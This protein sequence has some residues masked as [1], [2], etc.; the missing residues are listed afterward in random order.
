MTNL[1]PPSKSPSSHAVAVHENSRHGQAMGH[2]RGG[3]CH[4]AG[5]RE[6][7]RCRSDP[8]R[9]ATAWSYDAL[10]CS[11]S[12]MKERERAHTVMVRRSKL[13]RAMLRQGAARARQSWDLGRASTARHDLSSSHAFQV[14]EAC[15]AALNNTVNIFFG[16]STAHAT[17]VCL[18]V[19]LAQAELSK[20]LSQFY[21]STRDINYVYYVY[22]FNKNFNDF[23]NLLKNQMR[24]NIVNARKLYYIIVEMSTCYFCRAGLSM[25]QNAGRAMQLIVPTFWARH[26]PRVRGV[27]DTA[28]N[29][30]CHVMLRILQNGHAMTLPQLARPKSQL[31]LTLGII[32]RRPKTEPN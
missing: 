8:P 14:W 28:Q 2:R 21:F 23:H 6:G 30:S 32:N 7:R 29:L 26:N 24:G 4:V 27:I 25:A 22:Y 15:R 1:P 20:Y 13:W 11:T 19:M 12:K 16:P 9:M 31:Q 18:R 3:H 17:L 10:G 5:A